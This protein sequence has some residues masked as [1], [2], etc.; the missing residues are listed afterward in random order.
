MVSFKIRYIESLVRLFA[1]GS[2]S[3]DL[4][5]SPNATFSRGGKTVLSIIIGGVDSFL[6]SMG[7][8]TWGNSVLALINI[9]KL[10]L[11]SNT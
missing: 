2:R 5:F 11:I 3:S 8:G 1:L 9:K 7:V 4:R 10:R 6:V